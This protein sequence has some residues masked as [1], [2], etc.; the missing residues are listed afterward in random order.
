ME[1]EKSS[2]LVPSGIEGLKVAGFTRLVELL[3]KKRVMACR[4]CKYDLVCDHVWR[5]Y[6]HV[7]G[8]R[9]IQPVAGDVVLHPA[10]GYAVASSRESGVPLKT[11]RG[12]DDSRI[13]VKQVDFG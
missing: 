9:G 8:D 3:R 12:V 4:T 1:K 2:R 5:N 7:H 6:L 11:R 10:S 13:A